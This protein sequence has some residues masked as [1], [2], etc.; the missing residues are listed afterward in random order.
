M[1]TVELS[2]SKQIFGAGEISL[3]N[4]FGYAQTAFQDCTKVAAT[5]NPLTNTTADQP[6]SSCLGSAFNAAISS[7]GNGANMGGGNTGDNSYPGG[8]Y[9]ADRSGGDS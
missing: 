4:M 3:G 8:H 2:K 7:G 5:T 1:R 6:L 9:S